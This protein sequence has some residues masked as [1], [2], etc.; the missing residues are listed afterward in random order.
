M[1]Q[2]C[3]SWRDR[4]L[5]VLLW[6]TGLRIGEALGLRRSDLHLSDGSSDLGCLVVGPHVHVV[7]RD[8]V[9]RGAAKSRNDRHVAANRWVLGYYGRYLVELAAC[10]TTYPTPDRL[11]KTAPT[12]ASYAQSAGAKDRP[13]PIGSQSP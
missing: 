8:N 4:F 13:P 3:R 1:L 7:H 5:L 9:N 11:S 12:Q 6:S 2:Q 10:V